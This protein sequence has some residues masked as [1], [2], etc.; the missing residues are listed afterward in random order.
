MTDIDNQLNMM[1]Q[2][3][4]YSLSE[5]EEEKQRRK[6]KEAEDAMILARANEKDAPAI[7]Q[8]SELAYAKLLNPSNPE[9]VLRSYYETEASTTIKNDLLNKARE[10]IGRLSD[11]VTYLNTQDA[12][13]K[14]LPTNPVEG[15]QIERTETETI[16]TLYRKSELYQ[17]H[18]TT[19][20]IWTNIMNCIILA[21][22]IVMVYDLRSNLLDPIV[23]ITIL[24]T[25]ASVFILDKMI[26][27]LYGIPASIIQYLGWGADNVHNT[28]W[29][30]LYV[31][32]AAVLLYII[33]YNLIS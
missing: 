23:G 30:Y 28:A 12:Y 6:I 17:Q 9:G 26:Y 18:N 22:A 29:M 1:E 11:S 3:L 21:Y 33:I 13:V 32:V 5:T 4:N 20:L 7:R 31:P 27:I 8:Q 25:F 19:V 10:K 14:S 16:N 15:F 2:T 24:L